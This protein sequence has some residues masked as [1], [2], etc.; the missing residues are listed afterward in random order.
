MSRGLPKATP[1]V[2]LVEKED[3][4][5]PMVR[6]ESRTMIGVEVEEKDDCTRVGG[7]TSKLRIVVL[8]TSLNL[9]DIFN[10]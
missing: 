3:C 2:V 6:G 8:P 9:P 1:L 7:I 10:I 4:R 5:T